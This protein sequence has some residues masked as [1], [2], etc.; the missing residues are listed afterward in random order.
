MT[1]KLFVV[2]VLISALLISFSLVLAAKKAPIG[3]R[4]EVYV[5]QTIA[6]Q[7]TTPMPRGTLTEKQD[8]TSMFPDRGEKASASTVSLSAPGAK[9]YAAEVEYTKDFCDLYGVPAYA[10]TDWFWGMEWYANYQDPEEFGCVNVYPFEVIEI[11]FNIQVD[12]AMDIEVQG[13]VFDNAGTPECPVPGAQLC[14][15]P[16]YL[17]SI[18]SDGHWILVLPM[19]EQCCVYDPYFAGI[20]IYTDLYGTGSDAVSEDDPT[21]V[22]RSY[23][24]YGA[25]WEDLVVIYGWPGEMLLSSTGFTAPQNTC[26]G[27]EEECRFQNDNGAAASYFGSWNVGD[28]QAVYFDPDVMCV[29]CSEIDPVHIHTLEGCFYDHAGLG[30]PLEVIFHFYWASDPCNGP[31]AVEY[32]FPATITTFYPDVAVVPVPDLLCLEPE[33]KSLWPFF[34]ACEYNSGETGTI[35]SLLFDNNPPV[36]TCVQW[37]EYLDYGWIEW[38]DFWATPAEVGWIMM[39]AVGTC[40]A[41]A[42]Y[43]GEE[44]FMMQGSGVPASYFGSWNVDDKVA[45]YFDPEEFCMPP[46]YPLSVE[47]VKVALYDHAGVGATDVQIGIYIECSEPCDGPGTQIYLSD[48]F[49]VDVFYP[50]LTDIELEDVICVYE[51]FFV[52]VICASGETGTIPSVLFDDASVPMDTCHAWVWYDGYSPPWWEWSDFWAAPP[53][54]TPMIFV[55]AYTESPLC[56]IPPCD[57]TIEKLEGGIFANY[58][59][60]QPPNDEFLNMRFEMPSDHGGRLEY[61]NWANYEAGTSGTPD[62]DFYVWFSDGMYPLD[63]NPPYQ[64]I[65][66]FHI[67]Y[68][69]IVYYPGWTTVQ[70]YAHNL[71]FGPGEMFHIGVCHAYEAGDTLA[72][73]SDDGS[74]ESDRWSG[75]Y[76]GAWES[77]YPYEMLLDA[78]ICPFAPEGS[79]FTMKCTP[80][81]GYATPGDPPTNVYQVQLSSV[82]GYN[83][84]VTLSLLSVNPAPSTF[85]NATFV[86]NG[87]PCPYTSDVAIQVGAGEPYGDF[88]LTFQAVGADG[89]T[90][91][92]DVTLRLQPPFD[93]EIVEFFH[94][95]QRTTNFGA[96]GN[97]V[98]DNFVWY[99]TNYLFDGS[100]ISAVDVDPV[101]EHM[102]LD[103]FNCVHVGFVPTQHLV[104][105]DDPWCAGSEY[106]EYYGEVAYSHF[107]AEEDVI[108][109]EY[110][111]L[112]VIGLKHIDCTDFSIKIKIYYNPTPDPIPELWIGLYEDWDVGD[113][114]NNWVEMDPDHNLVW[115]YDVADPSIVFGILKAPFYDDMMHVI[116]GVNNAYYVWPNAGF[117]DD[118]GLDSLFYLMT[119]G[120]YYPPVDINADSNDMSLLMVPPPFELDT[121]PPLDKHIEIWIDF[122]RNLNDG[123]T[124][125]QWYHKILRYVG[126]YRGDVNASDTLELPA[127]DVSDLVY[128]INY[129]YKGGPAPLPFA[130]QGNVDCA[131]WCGGELDTDCPK[132]DCTTNDVVY[133]INYMWKGGPPPCDY[134]RFIPQLWSRPSLFLN[135]YWQ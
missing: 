49:P 58:Y 54:G 55:E 10:I 14:Q 51:P 47:D 98:R 111:S 123:M 13:F 87:L 114:Y 120:G 103:V 131:G 17:V 110:D 115:Q 72:P 37:N 107:Y 28:Q 130:D 132:N 2:L 59:W 53:P 86:P 29:D 79:T 26:E 44:C 64:A 85:I 35:P 11:Q 62:P 61:F 12:Y 70:T 48:P 16:V 121:I 71:V 32:S 38:W 25:G 3:D 60:K 76:E 94:G 73:L 23:N 63:N 56:D 126:F 116:R 15:T 84:N 89:Q 93:E 45:K 22:C 41:E 77:Y 78:F 127:L 4:A 83:L 1:K 96:V 42:C 129:L 9:V 21:D 18:P 66:D 7:Q 43:E 91:T 119:T 90:K 24:D 102:A 99:G 133:L 109:C 122:G 128:L 50:E 39:R 101:A 65:A 69:D 113:A 5:K 75:W 92:C 125:Q 46:V 134:I 34:L 57:T 36:D 135:P 52:A 88:T 20:Y 80:A 124:W 6:Q 30:Q 82:I 108:S 74:F 40:A 112:F 104:K 106:E 33:G 81:L 19:T 68:G 31:G 117:C 67:G 118:W 105:T 100:F 27:P 97:D 8:A 95:F